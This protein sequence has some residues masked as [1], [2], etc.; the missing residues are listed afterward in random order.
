MS[1]DNAPFAIILENS[2]DYYVYLQ[3]LSESV[4]FRY[5]LASHMDVFNQLVDQQMPASL[6]IIRFERQLNYFLKSY[7]HILSQPA[8]ANV[9]VLLIAN[10]HT[11]A[12]ANTMIERS[13][14][15]VIQTPID[16]EQM[17]IKTGA[18]LR[19]SLRQDV[20]LKVWLMLEGRTIE[21]RTLDISGTGVSVRVPDP[22]LSQKFTMRMFPDPSLTDVGVDFAVHVRRKEKSE[23][24]YH[25]GLQIVEHLDGDLDMLRDACGIQFRL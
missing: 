19:R 25:L 22:V 13:I 16:S 15:D 20:E 14:D 6:F 8:Y 21:G 3:D 10:E 4:G 5:V 9:P 11:M 2:D 17:K 18:M 24:G 7:M 12:Q 1:S 23:S